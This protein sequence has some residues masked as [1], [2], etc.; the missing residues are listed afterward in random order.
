[1]Q[2]K[3]IKNSSIYL[4]SNIC[5]TALPLIFLPVLT[6]FLEP[7]EYNTIAIFQ[8]LMLFCG[9]LF[10]FS[11]NG[12]CN[13]KYFELNENIE[14]FSIFLSN[15][16]FLLFSMAL[17]VTALALFF[18]F[19]K[20][21]FFGIDGGV[22]FLIPLGFLCQYVIYIRLGVYQVKGLS[23]KYG[24]LSLFNASINIIITVV[25][26]VYFES[27]YL[28][29]IVGILSGLVI[30]AIY[31]L[32]SLHRENLINNSISLESLRL[33]VRYGLS[34]APVIVLATFIPLLE[35]L[36]VSSK[37]GADLGGVFIV[38]TQISNGVLL[39]LSSI[40]TAY[41]PLVYKRLS[42]CED[43]SLIRKTLIIEVFVFAFLIAISALLIALDIPKTVLT[44]I[45]PETYFDAIDLS[46]LLTFAIVMKFGFI[47]WSIYLTYEKKNMYLSLVNL[48]FGFLGALILYTQLDYYGLQFVGYV[49]IFLKVTS[50]I[51]MFLFV[52]FKF[53][54][55][56]H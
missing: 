41:T 14:R 19:L 9:A 1:M 29:R 44:F 26:V 13:I 15:C 22:Y 34:Y 37:L 46:I 21:D 17:F 27:G 11:V 49:S 24:F 12:Y 35:R 8:S 28:G 56:S 4:L 16:L 31:S 33:I 3:L 6:R 40:A 43:D 48:F 18:F 30:V 5:V 2:S 55:K 39:I 53:F 10:G 25:L 32:Y 42:I 45:L 50:S 36:I 51:I 23:K 52:Y 54:K 7:H 47:M 20:V 38:A